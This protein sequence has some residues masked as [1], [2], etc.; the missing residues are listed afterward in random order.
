M[1]YTSPHSNLS[2]IMGTSPEDIDTRAQGS[3]RYLMVA[4]IALMMF[5]VL[6]VYSSIAYFAESKSTTAFT[7]I[8]GHII[9]LGIAFVVMLIASKINYHTLAKFSRLGMVVSW[10]LLVA[11]L[12]FGTE[13]FGAKRWLNLGGFSFQ[14]STVATV[15]LLLHVCVLLSEKQEYV[16]DFK[17][18]FMPIMVW[19]G[20]TCALIGVQDFSSAGIL[21][22]ICLIIMFIG[23]VSTIQLGTLVIAGVLGAMVL[24][25]MSENRQSRIDNYLQQ[26]KNIES[27]Q[28]LQGSG[29]Q[30]QQ[31][32]IA[33]AKGEIFGVGIGKSSQRDFLPAPYNDF[34]FAII[35][36]EYGIFGAMSL[37]LIFTLILFR[38]VVFISKNA[39]DTLG[40][41]LAVGCTLTI[42]LYGFVNA[43][44]ASGLLPVTGLPM[45]FVSYG[46]T[47]MLFAG[48]MI[49]ILLNI[50]K[51]HKDRRTMYYG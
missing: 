37:I 31:A 33:I 6:A 21:F 17:R 15:A 8:T 9:K 36:E 40:S 4:V 41:L 10:V 27:E 38:G 22:G 42:V 12:M 2:N 7:L 34:I 28:I 1:I 48:L 23:R 45:P 49:G 47:N 11:V 51:H 14:P 43:A 25:N 3:D 29:Y 50:S 19:V 16:K 5:G 26:V 35:A 24:L 18:S 20:I 13:Q 46:G 39:E 44:V 32:H 30:A